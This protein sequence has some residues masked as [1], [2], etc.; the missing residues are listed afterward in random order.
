MRFKVDVNLEK[1]SFELKIEKLRLAIL[2]NDEKAIESLKKDIGEKLNS[3]PM[4]IKQVTAKKNEVDRALSQSFWMN[5]SLDDADL[6][7]SE[8]LDLIQFSRPEAYKPIILDINDII[9]ESGWIEYGPNGEGD[10][11]NRYREKVERRIKE[12]AERNATI[13]KIKK[14]EIINDRDLKELE[15]ILNGPELFITEDSLR[16]V[17]DKNAG[18][19]VQFIKM[20]IGLYKFPEPRKRIEEA[21][22]SYIVEK[23]YL[24]ADQVNFLRVLQ[25]VF[26]SKHHVENV[27]FYEPPFTNLGMNV[28]TPLFNKTQLEDML[29]F[30]NNLELEIYPKIKVNSSRPK[31]HNV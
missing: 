7:E 26:T 28:P 22:Q 19:L 20:V 4:T 15:K 5:P 18:S 23:N 3:L 14:D 2:K 25:Q 17:Y 30:C 11:V 12:L 16:K 29:E 21:F 24:S 6:L 31:K 1:A 13:Q 10:Y 8:F 9:E 27:D